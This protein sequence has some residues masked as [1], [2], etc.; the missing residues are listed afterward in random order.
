M[1]QD[2]ARELPNKLPL[3]RHAP[4]RRWRDGNGQNHLVFGDRPFGLVDRDLTGHVSY[5]QVFDAEPSWLDM[6]VGIVGSSASIY[7]FLYPLG[8]R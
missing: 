7:V 1:R 2:A 3:S 4:A 6:L 8:T 5:E